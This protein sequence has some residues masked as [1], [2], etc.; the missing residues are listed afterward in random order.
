MDDSPGPQTNS[1]FVQCIL[2]NTIVFRRILK[3]LGHASFTS[4][5]KRVAHTYS[6]PTVK[7]SIPFIMLLRRV[8][9]T[10][11]RLSEQPLYISAGK[12]ADF[13]VLD[14]HNPTQTSVGDVIFG[15]FQPSTFIRFPGSLAWF[16]NSM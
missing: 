16:F 15:Y 3:K 14:R 13:V 12:A 8:D 7:R 11:K 1:N 9:N 6:R 5:S 4:K 2:T 10:S